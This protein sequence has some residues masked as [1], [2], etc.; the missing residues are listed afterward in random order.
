MHFNFVGN[1]RIG[2]VFST[3]AVLVAI[4]L[5]AS[6]GL[7]YGV[8][9]TGGS[10]YHYRFQ[11][12]VTEENIR[13]ALSTPQFE[14]LGEP[15]VQRVLGALE[16]VGE[17]E[18]SEFIIR[19]KFEEK[20]AQAATG[21]VDEKID[22]VLSTLGQA[23]RMGV[24]KIGP[25]IGQELR[26]KANWCILLGALIILSYISL[27]FEFRMAV[28][29]LIAELHDCFFVLGI[30]ALLQ[31]EF[32][33]DIL[34]A[35]LTIL[36]YSINDSIVVLDRIRENL[37]LKRKLPFD[38]IV[39]L[40]INQT[41]SRTINTALTTQLALMAL[42]VLGPLNVRDFALAMTIGVVVGTYSSICI[43]SPILVSWYYKDHPSASRSQEF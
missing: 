17:T 33:L 12:E 16:A 3:L 9:F 2:Y 38:E 1:R 6:V 35:V 27:R 21:D 13:Q 20:A 29:A 8:E 34:A 23:E 7:N 24:E 25:T 11:G 18:G 37:R 36:G 26:S 40:S 15:Q 19:T 43:V 5:L 4:G 10:I 22:R 42:L 39:N 31:H 41:L 14:E 28:A 32:T 30:F